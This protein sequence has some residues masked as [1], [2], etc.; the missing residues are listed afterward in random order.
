MVTR[1]R[2]WSYPYEACVCVGK[3]YLL[4]YLEIF[5]FFPPHLFPGFQSSLATPGILLVRTSEPWSHHKVPL[6]GEAAHSHP[7]STIVTD[8]LIAGRVSA[9][10]FPL[11]THVVS[12]NKR[13]QN[14][15]TPI[16]FV[17]RSSKTTRGLTALFIP[18][19]I[20]VEPRQSQAYRIM[21]LHQHTRPSLHLHGR[22][23]GVPVLDPT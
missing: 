19:F 18:L 2:V 3:P 9:T 16:V 15:D 8:I 17:A 21:R 12:E 20:Y 14:E 4:V 5:F 11:C 7:C 22:Q 23:Q 6:P 10:S 1:V 13:W